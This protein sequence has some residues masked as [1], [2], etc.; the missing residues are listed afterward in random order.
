[1]QSLITVGLL[2]ALGWTALAIRYTGGASALAA[3]AV[4]LVGVALLV[5]RRR[6]RPVR[7]VL[8]VLCGAVMAW[9]LSLAPRSD[10]PWQPDVATLPWAEVQ[11]DA[12]VV[13]NVRDNVYR[14]ETDYTVR[15]DDRTYS[16]AGLRSLDLFLSY[17]GSPWIAHT[18][19]SFGFDDGRYLAFSIE[20]RK[21]VG[22]EYSAVAGF[23]RRYELIYVV[24]DERDVV[25]LRTNYRGETVYLYRLRVP[26]ERVRARF[27]DY[28]RR[29]DQLRDR[30][31]WYNALV[32]NCTTEIPHDPLPWRSWK[33]LANG[34]LDE[35]AYE[36]GV[37]DRSL[38]FPVLRARSDITERARAADTAPDFSGRIRAGLPGVL[39]SPAP[40]AVGPPR[41]SAQ[42]ELRA[43][44]GRRHREPGLEL[45]DGGLHRRVEL[46]VVPAG[47]VV[48]GD[49]L[50][51]PGEPGERHR[52]VDGAVAP[53]DVSRILGARVL[54][55][56][57][58]Q[59]DPVSQVEARRPLRIA[60]EAPR[61][62]RRLVIGEVGERATLR[63][64]P[65]ARQLPD[66]DCLDGLLSHGISLPG[67]KC[68]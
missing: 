5:V 47:I 48:E 4:L 45:G 30:P 50:P 16:L 13:H 15:Y 62:E 61:A 59:V 22:E 26:I 42:D 24:A 63:L 14:T 54:G 65:V 37:V 53:A 1:V 17:W 23:F 56:V 25:R 66:Q 11:G 46:G 40:A 67:A 28:V 55:V 12:V 43:L 2:V 44:G 38:P 58:Q 39:A 41:R 6:R 35:L 18:I 21:E 49:Q 29:I 68:R 34:Y 20:T 60:R 33:L 52:V 64:D 36:M 32:H 8:A 57:D 19:V 10:R 9:W 27:L 31:E 7:L 51:D 3:A